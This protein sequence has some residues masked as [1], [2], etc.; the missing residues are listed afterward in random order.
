MDSP[1]TGRSDKPLAV[2]EERHGPDVPSGSGLEP[3]LE[4]EGLVHVR[5]EQRRL[6]RH[7]TVPGCLKLL[8]GQ[9][10]AVVRAMRVPG[11]V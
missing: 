2:R 8:V 3:S 7:D 1:C 9:P 5:G 4:V 6:R 11:I 10:L